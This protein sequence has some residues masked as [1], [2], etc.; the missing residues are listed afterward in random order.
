[1]QTENNTTDKKEE[2]ISAETILYK[3]VDNFRGHSR[4]FIY[5]SAVDKWNNIRTV[6]GFQS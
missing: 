4:E 2:R 5:D 6:K 3:C 1:M